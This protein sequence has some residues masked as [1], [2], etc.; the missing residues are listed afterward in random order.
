MKLAQKENLYSFPPE[1]PVVNA[2]QESAIRALNPFDDT[3][4]VKIP[5]Q[6]ILISLSSASLIAKGYIKHGALDSADFGIVK[7]VM[8]S[9]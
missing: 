9:S 7:I 3:G 8:F 1:V 2:S 5:A 4:L 6:L